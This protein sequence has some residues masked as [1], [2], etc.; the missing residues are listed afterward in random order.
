VTAEESNRMGAPEI[1]P[2]GLQLARTAKT[3]SRAFDDA[4]AEGGGSLP[5]WLILVSLK[6][7]PHG[8]QREIAEA[9]GVEGPT[10]THHLNRMEKAG[11]VTRRRDPDNRRVHQVELTD[12]GEATFFALVDK[13]VAF[14]ERLRHGLSDR[15][16]AQLRRLLDRLA[17]NATE[18]DHNERTET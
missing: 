2:V 11:L 9:V 3:V 17:A 14:D 15:D 18:P 6:G 5:L 10:L 16:L 4:L 7:Q 13:V 1:E 8:A 12:T